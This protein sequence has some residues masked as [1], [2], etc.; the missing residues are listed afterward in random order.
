[1]SVRLLLSTFVVII[2]LVFVINCQG[3]LFR[4]DV[5]Q[6][7]GLVCIKSAGTEYVTLDSVAKDLDAKICSSNYSATISK[8]DISAK[9]VSKDRYFYY[10]DCKIFIGSPILLQQ[11]KLYIAIDD[12]KLYVQP[13]FAPRSI[14]NSVP[15]LKTIVIDP[16]HGGRD[17]GTTNRGYKLEEKNLTLAVA[18]IVQTELKTLGFN[19]I[20]T[21]NSD[22][23]LELA[24]RVNAANRAKAD[25]FLSIH[26]NSAN[27]KSVRGVEIF[28]LTP[29]G[30]PSSS[31]SKK[32]TS[33]SI[34]LP[35][36]RFDH[37]N[38]V[39]GYSMLY[40]MKQRLKFDDRGVKH[41]RFGVLKG[42]S[43]PGVLVEVEFLS[44]DT[45]A[46]LFTAQGN[47]EKTALAIVNGVY[48][49]YLNM[50]AISKLKQ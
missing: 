19:A 26:F 32:T 10:N 38:T 6:K 49:Y 23:H 37:W 13:M 28:T 3:K 48:R 24:D 33:D 15:G 41:A 22:A 21:R 7:P 5:G 16:G 42:L 12:Y 20:L 36:N 47:L 27:T 4:A 50:K 35:G 39:A 44:N 17:S 31:S 9:F 18:K 2:C 29:P 11:K 25:L 43:C 34:A 46:R 45:V 14:A 40:S 30:Q 8:S 1:M